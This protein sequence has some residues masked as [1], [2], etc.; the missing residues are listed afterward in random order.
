MHCVQCVFTILSGQGTALNIDPSRYV[1]CIIIGNVVLCILCRKNYISGISYYRFYAHLYKNVLKVH[2]G[3]TH[4][5]TEIVLKT[6]IQLLI[7]QKKRITQT[8]LTAFIKRI[9]TWAL[10]SQHN[11]TLSI[12]GII[13]QV[14]QLGKAAHILLDTDISGN[15]YYQIEIEEPDYCN[16]HCTSLWEIVA[17]QVQAYRT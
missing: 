5:E 3:K 15:G 9:S 13:K 10:Q 6:L 14:M 1:L 16:A 8:R 12:L 4:L 7:Y 2:C 11:A 17:L